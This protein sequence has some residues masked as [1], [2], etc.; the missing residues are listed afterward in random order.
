MR[1]DFSAQAVGNRPKCMFGRV[2][3][4]RH[5]LGG[6]AATRIDEDDLSFSFLQHR[7]KSLGEG[8]GRTDIGM[9]K[10]VKFLEIAVL[11]GADAVQRGILYQKVKSTEALPQGSR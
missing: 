11:D 10:S 9:I 8:K 6:N 7:Q 2:I 4:G 5:R 3:L 1:I